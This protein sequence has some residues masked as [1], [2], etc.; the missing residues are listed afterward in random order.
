[1][2]TN[3]ARP[4]GI[5]TKM[6]GLNR[7]NFALYREH[8]IRAVEVS[9]AFEDYDRQDL[10]AVVADARAEAI[11]PW[12]FHLRFWPFEQYT[13]Q[14]ADPDARRFAVDYAAEWIKRAGD[15]GFAHTVIHPSGEP[16]EDAERKDAMERAKEAL[17]RLAGVARE[18]GTVLCVENLPRTCLAKNSTELLEL[19]AVDPSLRACFDTN[20]LLCEP[21]LDFMRAIGDKIV[22]L[23]LSDYDFI[24]ERH[25]LP[26]DGGVDWKGLMQT[27]DEIGYGGVMMYET[28]QTRRNGEERL[29]EV[30]D[31][32][33]NAAWLESLRA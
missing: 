12:S 1:M 3:I 11:D 7:A 19:L 31:Y 2:K 4:V 5:S 29:L 27:L 9:V 24:N 23:H 30:E 28:S 21:T 16:I 17:A 20:H 25:W 32:A 22:T 13:L 8:G 14:L 6:P 33:E 10:A 26:G 18:A 15:S